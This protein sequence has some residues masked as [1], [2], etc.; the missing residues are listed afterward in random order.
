MD[1]FFLTSEWSGKIQ[2]TE[3]DKCDKLKWVDIN[4][5]PSNIIPYI[6]YA[7]EQYVLTKFYWIWVV[8]FIW[9]VLTMNWFRY[10]NKTNYNSPKDNLK[11]F[12]Y[13]IIGVLIFLALSKYNII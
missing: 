4:N 5:L 12:F 8:N 9:K 7:I 11:D 2:K 13:F 10:F 6:K 1:Y 3:L